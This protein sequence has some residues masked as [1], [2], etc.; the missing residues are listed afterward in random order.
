MTDQTDPTELSGNQSRT[1]DPPHPR[2]GPLSEEDLEPK[3]RKPSRFHGPAEADTLDVNQDADDVRE[4]VHA[5]KEETDIP[6]LDAASRDEVEL[7]RLDYATRHLP[8][9]IKLIS[10]GILGLLL[11]LVLFLGLNKTSPRKIPATA[12]AAATTISTATETVS[13]GPLFSGPQA[14]TIMALGDGSVL[15]FVPDPNGQDSN[16]QKGF[17]M[18]LRPITKHQYSLCV[19]SGQCLDIPDSDT[20]QVRPVETPVDT[21]HRIRTALRILR[22]SVLKLWGLISLRNTLRFLP[23]IVAGSKGVYQQRQS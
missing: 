15:V 5:L 7:E 16:G 22:S 20:A 14:G 11:I 2:S 9:P 4:F 21:I 23:V 1:N 17:W 19:Q 8:G 18:T 10:G 13:Q 6:K 12:I 3:I